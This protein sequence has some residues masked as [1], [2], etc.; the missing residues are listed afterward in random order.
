[1]YY[2]KSCNCMNL[3]L[4]HVTYIFRYLCSVLNL[5]YRCFKQLIVV[6]YSTYIRGNVFYIFLIERGTGFGLGGGG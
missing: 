6:I 5:W 1:M 4:G 3:I 2:P